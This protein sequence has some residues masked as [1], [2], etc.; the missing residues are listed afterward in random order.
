MDHEHDRYEA[1]LK[2]AMTAAERSAFED[3]LRSDAGFEQA[4]N[5]FRTLF[6]LVNMAGEH[7]LKSK[8]ASIHG[9]VV[10][11]DTERTRVVRMF[12]RRW[13]AIAAS[14]L[15]AIAATY[16]FLGRSVGTQELYAQH[17][18]PYAGP[19]RTRSAGADPLDHWLR[20]TEL[21][22][23]GTYDEALS[24]LEAVPGDRVPAYL[25]SF[26]RGQCQLLKQHPDPRAAIAAF[27]QV[28]ATDNDMHAIAHWYT[29]LA[30]L[31]GNEPAIAK[32]H[33][34]VLRNAGDYKHAEAVRILDH[35]PDP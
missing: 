30:A 13:L 28:L 3:R 31:K 32:A 11:E 5:D 33:L 25:I 19:D 12:P 15:L 8:L 29:S 7:G 9:T 21:Y 16:F 17:M 14:L 27:G 23:G 2:E 18:A 35:L 22:D 6:D 26:Y 10:G 1:Y 20:F 24:E 4:F 34:E